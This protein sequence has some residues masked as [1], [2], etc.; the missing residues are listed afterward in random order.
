MNLNLK[1]GSLDSLDYFRLLIERC[2]DRMRSCLKSIAVDKFEFDD[3]ATS[4]NNITCINYKSESLINE[5]YQM[6]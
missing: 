2:Q 3:N 1:M 4:H 6:N 5:A